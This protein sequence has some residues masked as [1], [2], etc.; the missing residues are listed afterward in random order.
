MITFTKLGPL[1][2]PALEPGVEFE[3]EEPPVTPLPLL[4]VDGD[5]DDDDDDRDADGASGARLWGDG[6]L[7]SRFERWR[8]SPEPRRFNI[9]TDRSSSGARLKLPRAPKPRAFMIVWSSAGVV[10]LFAEAEAPPPPPPL[11]SPPP[12]LASPPPPL[13]P[14]SP[15]PLSSPRPL[16][17]MVVLVLAVV[18]AV[19]VVALVALVDVGCTFTGCGSSAEGAE[20]EEE[21]RSSSITVSPVALPSPPTSLV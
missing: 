19:P 13:P 15:P 2:E 9:S 11:A 4:E 21:A 16:P 14:L 7:R 8:L 12:P 5:D 3:P 20:R 10:S 6:G 17:L 18:P 1:V